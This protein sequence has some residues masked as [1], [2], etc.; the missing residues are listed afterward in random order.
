MTPRLGWRHSIGCSRGIRP[1]LRH[2]QPEQ[3]AHR[4]SLV[5]SPGADAASAFTSERDRRTTCTDL[6][7]TLL[8]VGPVQPG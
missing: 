5:L 4:L 8:G 1:L 3:T 6:I 7:E 2:D